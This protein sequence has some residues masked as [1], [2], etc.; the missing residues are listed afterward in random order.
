MPGTV[1]KSDGCT[2]QIFLGGLPYHFSEEQCRQLLEPFG[3][4]RSFELVRDREK[5]ESK[6]YG[7]AVFSD[8]A[9]TDTAIVGLNGLSIDGRVLTCRKCASQTPSP[10]ARRMLCAVWLLSLIHI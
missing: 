4:L 8:S 5:G 1:L 9:V 2:V 6:G 3:D 7:F 10:L